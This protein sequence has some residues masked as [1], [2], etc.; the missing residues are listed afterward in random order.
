MPRNAL[1][2]PS[3]DLTYGLGPSETLGHTSL[4]QASGRKDLG[5]T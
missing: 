1:T 4:R 3:K 5:R 2:F